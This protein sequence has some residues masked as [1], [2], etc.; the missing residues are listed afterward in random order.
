M[1]FS[2][3]SVR[4]LLLGASGFIG[5][6]V[7]QALLRSG[8]QVTALRRKRPPRLGS[9]PWRVAEQSGQL[10]WRQAEVHH[11][12]ASQDWLPWLQGVHAVINCV[13]ILRQRLGE[14]YE[15]VH[16]HMPA[17]LASACAVN[18]VRFIHTSALGLYE[19]AASRFLSSKW[20]GE[21][22]LMQSAADFCIVRPSLIDGAGGFG[23]AWL[24]MLS[25]WP[26]HWVPRGATG[27]ISALTAAD[28]GQAYAALV[29]MPS[30][31]Q[32]REANLGGIRQFD[33]GEYLQLLR[34][35]EEGARRPAL[36]I[37][38]PNWL[39]R[40]G[41]HGCDVLRF[42]PFSFGHWLLL[43]RDNLAVPNHLPGLLGR[44]PAPVGYLGGSEFGRVRMS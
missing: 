12:R 44:D 32:Q 43:Q 35:V 18:G 25:S 42:S 31:E 23:A 33:Y 22:A 20:R 21:Q 14:S 4:V 5:G 39:T 41:A 15:D 34:G 17:A 6:H 26:V 29:A 19:G 28:L 9:E 1:N 30:F 2:S 3:Q 24:R 36:Q 40:L 7:L 16:H 38:M 37:T 8:F 27:R 13:G 10:V 11:M